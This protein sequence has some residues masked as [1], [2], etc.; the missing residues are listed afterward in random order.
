LRPSSTLVIVSM[1]PSA[2]AL[3]RPST[4]RELSKSCCLQG[5]QFGLAVFRKVTDAKRPLLAGNNYRALASDDPRRWW[6]RRH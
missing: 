6:V 4:S 2:R 3:W 1:I 5:R